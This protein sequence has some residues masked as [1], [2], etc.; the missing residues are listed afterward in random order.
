MGK[1]AEGMSRNSAKILFASAIAIPLL[2]SLILILYISTSTDISFQEAVRKYFFYFMHK[3]GPYERVIIAGLL[4]GLGNALFVPI[5]LLLFLTALLMPGWRSFTA[6]MLG[7]LIAALIGYIYGQFL[8]VGYIQNKLGKKFEIISHEIARDGFKT[9]VL[10]C[11]API[12]PNLLTNILAGICRI[13]IWKLL[14]GTFV[15]FVPGITLLTLLGREMRAL[16][17]DPGLQTIFWL[18]VILALFVLSFK[19]GKRI[20]KKLIVNELELSERKNYTS[21][22]HRLKKTG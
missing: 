6:G 18:V 13:P 17:K 7:A 15:G 2:I 19:I 11:I 21:E 10:L 5:N 14:T 1:L 4:I 8:N 20:K 22:P 12:A 9:V 3:R 16:V